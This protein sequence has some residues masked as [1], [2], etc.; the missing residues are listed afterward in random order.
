MSNIQKQ[1]AEN[2]PNGFQRE[3]ILEFWNKAK[4]KG[5]KRVGH[6]GVY[7]DGTIELVF[8]IG[9]NRHFVRFP[10]DGGYNF[11]PVT[12]VCK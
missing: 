3:A 1:I 8:K 5:W 4:P 7:E 2:G 12:M 9:R 11:A 10:A 6:N